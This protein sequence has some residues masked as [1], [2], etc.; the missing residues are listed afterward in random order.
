MSEKNRLENEK[1]SKVFY[2]LTDNK[3]KL[4]VLDITNPLFV[5]S[6]NE[7]AL[8]E[9]GQEAIKRKN[10]RQ[11]PFINFLAKRS[12]TL[13]EFLPKDKSANYVSGMSTLMMK[14]GPELIGGGFT[15]FF[16][17]KVSE[18]FISMSVR[19]RLR[20]ICQV[21]AEAL[22]P[23]L[24]KE[25]RTNLC[26]INIAGGAATDNINT[27]IL[28]KKQDP[29]LLRNRTIEIDVLDV[30][31]FGPDFAKNSIQSLKA[32]GG[33]FQGMDVSFR[34]IPYDWSETSK[35]TDLLEERK[36]WIQICTSEGGLFEYA[37]D[38]DI[39]KNLIELSDH[40]SND[41]IIVG[42]VVLESE[43]VNPAFPAALGDTSKKIRFIG[44]R[45]LKEILG[46]TGWAINKVV[47]G[48]PIYVIFT[49][50]KTK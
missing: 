38:E 27:L 49:L 12:L 26:F 43:R 18:G 33:P 2:A 48:N 42:D 7:K 8:A 13:G 15:R 36:D 31:T 44:T 10:F 32:D 21:Q 22:A 1:I 47:E 46:K 35:L 28:L 4:P 20:D 24:K 41:L 14:L 5:S 6:I 40:A 23:L 45:G 30:D 39:I 50:K 19:M 37:S 3:I 17:R 16:D 25:P 9:L 11:S 29:D 34:H